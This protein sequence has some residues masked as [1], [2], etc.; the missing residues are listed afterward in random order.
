MSRSADRGLEVVL[1]L[2]RSRSCSTLDLVGDA[3]EA[4]SLDELADL[5]RLHV[6]DPDVQGHGLADGSLAASSTFP[7][8]RAFNDTLR[9]TSFSSSTCVSARRRSSLAVCNSIDLSLRSMELW[10]SL[11][12]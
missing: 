7:Y 12:S 9:F 10:V 8:E 11:K 3:L 4:E 6:G 1:L 5:A 2:P